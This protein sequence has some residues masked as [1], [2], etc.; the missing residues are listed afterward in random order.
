MPF[1]KRFHFCLYYWVNG[2]LNKGKSY[3][4]L[5]I[6][7]NHAEQVEWFSGRAKNQKPKTVY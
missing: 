1:R 4:K 5:K 6:Y 3:V 2:Q 7:G